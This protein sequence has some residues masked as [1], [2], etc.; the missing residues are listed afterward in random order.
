MKGGAMMDALIASG[1][2]R[3]EELTNDLWLY[4]CN[5][6]EFVSKTRRIP[7]SPICPSCGSSLVSEVAYVSRKQIRSSKNAKHV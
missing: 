3:Q 5:N 7:T 2:V 1:L 6:C 4:E